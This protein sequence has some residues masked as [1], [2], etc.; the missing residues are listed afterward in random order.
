MTKRLEI[1]SIR[2]KVAIVSMVCVISLMA[3]LVSVPNNVSATNHGGWITADETWY[4]AGNPHVI[5]KDLR[6][7]PSVT[8]TIMQGVNV[9]VSL[10]TT[11]YV[12]GDLLVQESGYEPVRF[13]S[14]SIMPQPGDWGSI[15]FNSSGGGGQPSST[16]EEAVIEHGSAGVYV[17][18]RSLNIR[19]CTIR[20]NL[21]GIDSNLG[22]LLV[23]A[24]SIHDNTY[25]GISWTGWNSMSSLASIS[26][27]N[28]T[29]NGGNGLNGSAGAIVAIVGNDISFN[30][31]GI[32]FNDSTPATFQNNIFNNSEDGIYF[33]R[34]GNGTAMSNNTVANNSK[35]G[36]WVSTSSVKIDNN[37]LEDNGLNGTY[38]IYYSGTMENNTAVSN[39]GSG[40]YLVSSSGPFLQYNNITQN[41]IHGVYSD[42]SSITMRENE[43]TYNSPS[44]TCSDPFYC[45]YSGIF[46]NRGSV[47]QI[48]HN[49]VENNTLHGIFVKNV[50]LANMSDN[51]ISD[52]DAGALAA[53]AGIYAYQS[54]VNVFR[55]S[56]VRNLGDVMINYY[57]QTQQS[58]R[59]EN[60]TMCGSGDAGVFLYD[61]GSTTMI[62]NNSMMNIFR[63]IALMDSSAKVYNNHIQN[64]QNWAIQL[65]DYSVSGQSSDED[66]FNNTI[67]YAVGGILLD[68]DS[69][70]SA[71]PLIRNNS[72]SGHIT[73]QIG[74]GVIGYGSATPLIKHNTVKN[75]IGGYGIPITGSNAHPQIINNTIAANYVGIYL[76][77]GA[78]ATINGCNINNNTN[79]GVQNND[80]TILVNAEENWWGDSTG[81][82]HPSNPFGNGDRV[83]NDIDFIPWLTALA[84]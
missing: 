1:I 78:N 84:F 56:F 41:E 18:S 2:H 44:A 77:S 79:F 65:D 26:G 21:I 43:I 23:E 13:S 3:S 54:G 48:D 20:D 50:T 14:S 6:V 16:I 25:D 9:S 83:S 39:P 27:N 30:T 69:G 45:E 74:I 81:P 63:G 40:I 22:A 52:H 70:E 17:Y 61:Y 72:I 67:V 19:S 11:L 71:S 59:I 66:V 49:R 46:I 5:V 35:N 7:M 31:Y 32:R 28:I 8:L 15:H 76:A 36:I 60:N 51:A 62:A 55:N 33:L 47:L 82:T 58:N 57:Q 12:D 75:L 24:S 53:S 38:G 4:K 37:T 73:S 29:N 34:S 64:V 42:S 10:G 68:V 80:D